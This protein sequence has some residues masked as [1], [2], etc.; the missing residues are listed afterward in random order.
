MGPTLVILAAGIG[1]RYGGLKQLDP[2]GPSGEALLHYSLFDAIREG[3]E[4]VVFVVRREIENEVRAQV[5][6]ALSA[7]VAVEY[8]CQETPS[9]RTK[10]WGTGQATLLCREAV[11]NP[12][13]VINADDFYG[14]ESFSAVA[15]FLRN[16]SGTSS[17]HCLVGFELRKTLSEHGSVARGVCDVRSGGELVGIEEVVAIE[18]EGNGARRTGDDGA[19]RRLSGDERVSMNMWGL[20][21]SLFAQLDKR[22]KVFAEAHVNDAVSEFYLPS[23][24]GELIQDGAV[25]VRMLE[26]GA[27]WSGMT[28]QEDKPTVAA[29]IAKLVGAGEYPGKI[30]FVP[31]A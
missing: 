5:G 18:K 8:V 12:F 28:Y 16:V 4:K 7:A 3:F 2:V 11:S 10:P 15:G 20:M 13:A 29:E 17:K 23:V 25:S 30:E 22:F 19:E 26:T 21:P 9:G 14:R 24:I 1:R 27:C 6:D 31:S